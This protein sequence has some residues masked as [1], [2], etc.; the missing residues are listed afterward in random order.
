MKD[1]LNLPDENDGVPV[2]ISAT[3]AYYEDSPTEDCFAW[4]IDRNDPTFSCVSDTYML[5]P[6]G[7][8]ELS[9][10][11]G[12]REYAQ[13]FESPEASKTYFDYLIDPLNGLANRL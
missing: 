2:Y 12:Q 11:L 10:W 9:W 7:V 1:Y 3:D 4:S 8:Q 6:E 5:L 13:R